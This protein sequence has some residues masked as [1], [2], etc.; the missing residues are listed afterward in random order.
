VNPE[1]FIPEVIYTTDGRVLLM[2][3]DPT[4]TLCFMCR[5]VISEDYTIVKIA[6]ELGRLAHLRCL[7]DT[8][9]DYFEG[10]FQG[11]HH[12]V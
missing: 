11:E 2:G 12:D 5:E 4:T 6:Y 3:M 7:P 10:N 9:A 8:D 1:D